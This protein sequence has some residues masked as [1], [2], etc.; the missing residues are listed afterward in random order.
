MIEVIRHGN[1]VHVY[2]CLKCGCLFRAN[3]N[4]INCIDSGGSDV[5]Y[6]RD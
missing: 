4:D 1:Y 3:K 6:I 2:K 5:S